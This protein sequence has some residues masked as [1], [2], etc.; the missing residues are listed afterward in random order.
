MCKRKGLLQTTMLAGVVGAVFFLR[1]QN[2]S[3]ADLPAQ[4]PV[5]APPASVFMPAVDGINWKTGALGGTLANRTVGAWQGSLTIPLA[6]QY[7]VQIDG[8]AGTFDGKFFASTAGHWFWRNPSQGLLGLY[9]SHTHWDELGGVHATQVAVEGEYYWQ[10]WTLQATAGVEFGNSKSELTNG[11][12]FTDT[13][14]VKT[15]FYDKVNVNYYLTDNW[16]AFIGHR[17]L[18]GKHALALG[19][20]VG[21]PFGRGA[22]ATAFVEGRVGEADFHGV[23]G[24][25][26]LYFGQKDKPLIARHRQDDPL[27]W[28]P[29]T[30]FTLTNSFNRTATPPNP[31]SKCP[32]GYI[33]IP[34]EGCFID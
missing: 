2:A 34:G 9:V 32:P 25:L 1:M 31:T 23:W 6:A 30:L 27:N 10:R 17:Y 16:K 14:D 12:A 7:G 19:S 15:R 21:V 20:E 24:G 3:A 11:G 26:K 33:Y 13:I 29:D 28:D 4:L 5:K 18:G 8:T 22:M